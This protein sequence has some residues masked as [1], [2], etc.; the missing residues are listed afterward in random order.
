[1]RSAAPQGDLLDR[2]GHAA[3]PSRKIEELARAFGQ[4]H[5]LTP[6]VVEWLRVLLSNVLAQDLGSIVA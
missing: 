6:E 5:G 4:T 3:A 1:M 2:N